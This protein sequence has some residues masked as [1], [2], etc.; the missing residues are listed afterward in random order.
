ME[1]TCAATAAHARGN[2]LKTRKEHSRTSTNNSSLRRETSLLVK[3]K[4]NEMTEHNHN[5][6][7]LA[8]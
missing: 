8:R 7:S 5:R 2:A 6:I 3:K 1:G 4:G